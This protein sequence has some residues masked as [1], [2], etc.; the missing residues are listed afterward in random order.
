MLEW[1]KIVAS[2]LSVIS[3]LQKCHMLLAFHSLTVTAKP[4]VFKGPAL[5]KVLLSFL[6]VNHLNKQIVYIKCGILPVIHL[7]I[8]QFVAYP[9]A[10]FQVHLQSFGAPIMFTHFMSVCMKQ[11]K[12]CCMDFHEI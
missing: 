11:L 6:V 3:I 12:S 5:M 8:I 1:C 4:S 9:C 2:R 10:F 7:R